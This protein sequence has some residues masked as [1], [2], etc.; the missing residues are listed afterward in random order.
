MSGQNICPHCFADGYT[1]TCNVCGYQEQE[2][3]PN[4]LPPFTVLKSRY[5]LG[6]PIGVGGFGIT[7][8]AKNMEN[9]ERIAVKEYFPQGI[10]LR[11]AD[12]TVQAMDGYRQAFRHGLDRFSMEAEVLRTFARV[13]GIV[14]VDDNFE[15]NGT[16]YIVMEYLSGRTLKKDA[17]MMGG[18]YPFARA[19]AV[20]RQTAAALA[21]VH[22]AGLLHR[23]ISPDNI[24]VDDAGNA[25]LIDFGAAR[26]YMQQQ[27]LTVMMKQ[28]YA[29][30]EQYSSTAAQGRYTDVYALGCTLY[31][32]LTGRRVPEAPARLDGAV[33]PPLTQLRP[34]LPGS[35]SAAIEKAIEILPENRFQTMHEFL[36]TAEGTGGEP[37]PNH[38]TQGSS[39]AL[40]GVLRVLIGRCAGMAV[41]FEGNYDHLIGRSAGNGQIQ[42]SMDTLSKTHFGVQYQP[43]KRR[44]IVWDNHSTNGSFF[45]NG[46]RMIPDCRYAAFPG[47]IFYLA[48]K[49]CA[50][51]LDVQ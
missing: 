47:D 27:E 4:V 15:W 30:I 19:A 2:H 14:R 25:N 23:D 43:A 44:F 39:G 5:L 13:P 7:Y 32:T 41:S 45:Q 3:A 50:I 31:A 40:R 46:E 49:E 1:G 33:T 36:R 38:P 20:L 10:A 8:A 22:E 35:F 28:G 29:P 18:A 24:M 16:G 34:D 37:Q 11:S 6:T 48:D 9:G 21:Q 12:S 42:I 17:E 51:Q 26:A